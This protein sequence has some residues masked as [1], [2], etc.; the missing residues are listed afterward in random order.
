MVKRKHREDEQENTGEAEKG[1]RGRKKAY[2]EKP[3]DKPV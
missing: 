1:R 2:A 3:K